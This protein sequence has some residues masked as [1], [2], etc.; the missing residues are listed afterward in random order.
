MLA[1]AM[2]T[3]DPLLPAGLDQQESALGQHDP[4]AAVPGLP[5][6]PWDAD[7][8]LSFLGFADSHVNGV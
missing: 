4:A 6:L 1:G 7:W 8:D 5:T 3:L 2:G